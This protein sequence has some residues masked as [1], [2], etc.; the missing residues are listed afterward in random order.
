MFSYKSILFYALISVFSMYGNL[1]FLPSDFV[2]NEILNVF[3]LYMLV[4]IDVFTLKL[5]K[6]T[7]ILFLAKS[8]GRKRSEE[9]AVRWTP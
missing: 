1:P 9:S 8:E 2:Q 6:Q 5:K 3:M 7:F 4:R